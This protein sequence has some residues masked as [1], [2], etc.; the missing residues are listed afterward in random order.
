[1]DEKN[2]SNMP[3]NTQE[4]PH[5]SPIGSKN[6]PASVK[7]PDSELKKAKKHL[8]P[9]I[10]ISFIL[11]FSISLGFAL[12]WDLLYYWWRPSYEFL[13]SI[14]SIVSGIVL[15]VG[16]FMKQNKVMSM[17]AMLW[18]IIYAVV[19]LSLTHS[20]LYY[21]GATDSNL[22]LLAFFFQFLFM[23]F[24]QS[25]FNPNNTSVVSSDFQNIPP[26]THKNKAPSKKTKGVLP[27]ITGISFLLSSLIIWIASGGMFDGGFISLELFGIAISILLFI[28][29]H[30]LVSVVATLWTTGYA[31]IL[32]YTDDIST[33]L[34][35]ILFLIVF[36][37]M[38]I[39]F[40]FSKMKVIQAILSKIWW[41]PGT[42]SIFIVFLA[43][44][45]II[46]QIALS[47]PI[48][49]LGKYLFTKQI[50]KTTPAEP[51]ITSAQE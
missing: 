47:L 33:I 20:D 42:L 1:M 45:F 28:K 49:L 46:D 37:F 38:I 32:S 22:I 5:V 44:G 25:F 3:Q 21:M 9:I 19:M 31:R 34:G 26:S 50:K 48:L 2:I 27:I 51:Q 8:F 15:A 39:R 24:L 40:G 11:S 30:I 18:G 6:I 12:S 41:I 17:I 14:F 36:L 4:Q 35:I 16:L 29:K 43:D 7:K 13:L 23:N 10:G